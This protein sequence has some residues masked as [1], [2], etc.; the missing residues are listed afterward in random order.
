MAR[1]ARLVAFV[2]WVSL[3]Y[4]CATTPAPSDPRKGS[5]PHAMYPLQAGNAWSYDVDTGESSTTLAITRVEE[6]DGAEARVRTGTEVVRYELAPEG[7]RTLPDGAWLFRTPF[8]VGATWTARGGRAASIVTVD[9]VAKTPAGS[10]EGCL[11]VLETGGNLDLEIRTIYCPGVGPVSVA[12]TL[13]SD[14]SDRSLTVT[15]TLRGY[16][17][18]RP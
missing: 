5:D 17:V 13:R 15:A 14:V 3:S 6:R 2:I 9:A 12:S 10:F 1:G 16:D 8:T 4:G 11:E 18:S 7:V